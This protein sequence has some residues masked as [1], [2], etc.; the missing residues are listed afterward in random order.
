MATL[1]SPC[2]PVL[3]VLCTLL[4]SAS[5]DVKKAAEVSKGTEQLPIG[6]RIESLGLCVGKRDTAMVH[7]VVQGLQPMA[8]L[9]Q[10]CEEPFQQTS[11]IKGRSLIAL[12]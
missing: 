3:Y 12:L 10:T 6:E 8:A 1:P 11:V 5:P 9:R 2:I 7:S 4:V